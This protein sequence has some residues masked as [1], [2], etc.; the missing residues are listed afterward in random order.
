[1]YNLVIAYERADW[2]RVS[3]LIGKVG[4]PEGEVPLLYAE[5]VAWADTLFRQIPL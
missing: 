3:E 1:V 5:A 4:L 2:E